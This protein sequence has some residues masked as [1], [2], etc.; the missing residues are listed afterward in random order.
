MKTKSSPD[1]I[2]QIAR[3]AIQRVATQR[4]QLTPENYAVAFAQVA[5]T[6]ATPAVSAPPPAVESPLDWATLIGRLMN[7]IDTHRPGI[8]LAKKRDGLQRSLSGRAANA[9]VLYQRLD[10]LIQSWALGSESSQTEVQAPPL[11]SEI[12]QTPPAQVSTPVAQEVQSQSISAEPASTLVALA[13]LFTLLL[14]NVAELT[15]ENGVL[16]GQISRIK[17]LFAEPINERSLIEAKRQVRTMIVTQGIIKH[18]LEDAKAALKQM[19]ST[20]VDRLS[21]MSDATG[22]YHKKIESY[23]VEINSTE[24]FTK[25]SH[26]V[27]GLLSD[28]RGMSTDILSARQELVDTRQRVR[29]QDHKIQ[30]MEVELVRIS[31]LVRTDPLTAALNR[32]GFEEVYAVELARAERTAT[33]LCV[34][35]IDL[36]DF[37][38]LNDKSGHQA[39]DDALVH[40]VAVI[41]EM[42]RPT[43]AVGRYG[44]EEFVILYP[45]TEL[46]EAALTTTRIQRSLTKRFF[47][48]NNEK[49]FISF[50]AG[51]AAVHHDL[52]LTEALDRADK[53]VY[54][55]KASGKNRVIVA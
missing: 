11:S 23:V 51:V 30:E 31:E 44:G 41:K 2:A 32:R 38:R 52:G 19:L 53:A 36:D 28:T 20:L 35:L 10:K 17:Q 4:L 7:G 55:A 18:G 27:E 25:L 29:D 37:K 15:P 45:D 26:V 14:D 46:A 42:T 16:G 48:H 49:L 43:D 9:Q 33:P 24:D 34:A 40:L 3:E 21:A 6:T 39:G 50:S 47:L 12:A 5:G 8:T 1:K 22:D 54:E 13:E